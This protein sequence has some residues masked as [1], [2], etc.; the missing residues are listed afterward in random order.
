MTI[1]NKVTFAYV[2]DNKYS[3]KLNFEYQK[4]SITYLMI[5]KP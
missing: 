4:M 3:S 1:I 2:S 5:S